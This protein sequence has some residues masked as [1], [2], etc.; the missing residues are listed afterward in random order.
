MADSRY[1]YILVFD[2]LAVTTLEVCEFLNA[3]EE[4]FLNWST[5]IPNCFFVVSEYAAADLARLFRQ[6]LPDRSRFIIADLDTDKAGSLA[7]STWAF[8]ANPKGVDD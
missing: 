3:N 4:V 2:Q 8:I 7:R 5:D 6:F 1:C